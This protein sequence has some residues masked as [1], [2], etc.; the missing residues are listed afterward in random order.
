M[1]GHIKRW[2]ARVVTPG[3]LQ[4]LVL[5]KLSSGEFKALDASAVENPASTGVKRFRTHL[6]IHKKNLIGI[7][8]LDA[9]VHIG[10]IP[11]DGAKERG[12]VPAMMVGDSATPNSSYSSS[13]DEYQF[14]ATLKP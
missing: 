14:N 1:S 9:T 6:S 8:L 4:L 5:K 7:S 11:R 13:G 10:G 2:R 3:S 12:F